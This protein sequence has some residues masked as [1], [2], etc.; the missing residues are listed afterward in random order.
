M[1]LHRT[2]ALFVS[3]AAGV[4]P[5]PAFAKDA[6]ASLLCMA[7]EAT[8]GGGGSSCNKPI[9]DFLSIVEYRHGH[10]DLNATPNARRSY[11]NSC[12]GSNQDTSSID[13]IISAFGSVTHL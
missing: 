1:K 9:E 12:P 7:G 4:V 2:I 11:L 5:P 6:C 10:V 3:I 13:S 8:G